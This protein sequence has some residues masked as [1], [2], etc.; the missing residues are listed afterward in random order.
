MADELSL[1]ISATETKSGVSTEKSFTDNFDVSGIPFISAIQ[2]IG[3]SDETL[4]LG[5]VASLGWLVMKNTDATNYV[6]I[7]YTS[8]T[9]FAKLKAGEFCAFRAGAGLTAIHAKANT[10]AINLEYVLFS[11]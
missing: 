5:D 4:Q 6:E 3:T 2:A 8:G 9:Y 11:D 7:G 10:G 1:A